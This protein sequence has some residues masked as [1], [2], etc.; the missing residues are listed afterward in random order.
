MAMAQPSMI[1]LVMTMPTNE[2]NRSINRLAMRCSRVRSLAVYIT[3]DL[4]SRVTYLAPWLTTSI[5]SKL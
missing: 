4:S 5:I 1:G 2:M 3:M